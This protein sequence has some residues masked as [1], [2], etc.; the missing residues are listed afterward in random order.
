MQPVAGC[1]STQVSA[2][3]TTLLKNDNA[4]LWG[5]VVPGTYVGTVN[6]H[7][8]G[9]AGGTS[10][11]SQIISLGLPTTSVR[12]DINCYGRECKNGLLYQATGTPVLTILWS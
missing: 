2:I 12:Y 11:S 3:G 6:I 8:A 10:G 7:D 9:S 5:V 4:R 1:K